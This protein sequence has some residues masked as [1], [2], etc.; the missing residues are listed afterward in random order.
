MR[1]CHGMVCQVFHLFFSFSYAFCCFS[2]YKGNNLKVYIG[3]SYLYE[4]E[5]NSE[6]INNLIEIT[7]TYE[8]LSYY[9]LIKNKL[10]KYYLVVKGT[11]IIDD[12]IISDT[13]FNYNYHN[14]NI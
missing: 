12:I 1:R 8:N 7:D 5:L 4:F 2:F 11:G 13:N 3:I 9:K 6:Y 10:N 14:K